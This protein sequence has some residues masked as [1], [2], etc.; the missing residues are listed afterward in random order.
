MKLAIVQMSVKQSDFEFNFEK[1]D[2]FAARAKREGADM[3]VFPEMFVCGFSYKKNLEYVLGNPGQPQG[4]LSQIA[5]RNKIWLCGSAPYLEGAQLPTNRLWLFDQS[6]C[7]RASYDKMHLFSL[8]RENLYCNPGREICVAETPF[9]KIGLSICYDLRFPKMFSDMADAGAG[10][11]I[12]V[13]AWPYP[14][15]DHW[16]TL[17]RARAV[18]NQVFFVCVNQCGTENFGQK[19]VKYFGDSEV[20]GPWGE[21]L[22][23]CQIDRPDSISF[24]DIDFSLIEEARAKLPSYKDKIPGLD[25]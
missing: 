9:G 2:A 16:Q 25:I 14:R 15:L 12:L 1:A 23:D 17:S 10:I 21:V 18:E 20:I 8:F 22:A 6:G 7:A 19:A 13:G 11:I 4:R 5:E 24:C 3:V